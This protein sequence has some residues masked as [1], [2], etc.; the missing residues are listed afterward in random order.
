M[1]PYAWECIAPDDGRYLIL[2]EGDKEPEGW[3]SFKPLYSFTVKPLPWVADSDGDLTAKTPF[4][5][6]E[7]MWFGRRTMFAMSFKLKDRSHH[8]TMDEA[9]AAAEKYYA[10]LVAELLTETKP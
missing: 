9:K 10:A 2:A 8:K 1:K 4:G 5:L 3:K 7:V 6:F